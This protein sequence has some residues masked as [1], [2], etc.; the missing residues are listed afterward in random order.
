[1]KNYGQDEKS[2]FIQESFQSFFLFSRRRKKERKV[3]YKKL[4]LMSLGKNKFPPISVHNKASKYITLTDDSATL[5]FM[6]EEKR[7][8]TFSIH[9][10]KP[11]KN[12]PSKLSRK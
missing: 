1:L 5:F 8:K 4:A 9:V 6:K 7:R 2:I 10:T 3:P 12:F 11:K